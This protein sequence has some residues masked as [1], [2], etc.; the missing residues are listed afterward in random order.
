MSIPLFLPRGISVNRDEFEKASAVWVT[1]LTLHGVYHSFLDLAHYD[2]TG[3]T[4]THVFLG[5][6]PNADGDC[7]IPGEAV[8]LWRAGKITP[9]GRLHIRA[10]GE[11]I[12]FLDVD[13]QNLA[14]VAILVVRATQP[15][16][17]RVAL[18]VKSI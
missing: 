15:I 4:A 12:L 16:C 17:P 7:P 14:Q 11:A 13:D 5:D 9:I 18:I 10:T 6:H 3:K 8:T 1:P 2:K